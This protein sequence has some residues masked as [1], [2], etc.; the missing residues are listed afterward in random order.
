MPPEQTEHFLTAIRRLTGSASNSDIPRIGL[1]VS[2]GPDSLALLLLAHTALPGKFATATV[3]HGLRPGAADEAAY[4]GQLCEER[5]IPHRILKPAHAITGNI[6]SE[7]RKARYGLLAGWAE[8]EGC[9]WIATA[10]HADDQLET[11]LMRLARGS[12][13]D[14]LSGIRAVNGQI[15]RPLLDTSKADLVEICTQAGVTAIDDPSNLDDDFDRVRMRKW[16]AASDSPLDTKS[17][18]KSAGHLGQASEALSWMTAKLSAE[19]I[20]RQGDEV[21]LDSAG[22]P[23]EL[24]RRLLHIA[25]CE[26]DASYAPRGPAVE[27]LLDSLTG[28]DTSTIGNILCRGGAQWHF[29]AAPPRQ[30]R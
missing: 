11:L 8:E 9:C 26:I 1:A 21:L 14:G 4:V 15:I 19:R 17:A 20:S 12:G 18:A 24:Q 10:H 22:L 2:G 28:G 29:S 13:V 16:L 27:R 25:L 7:A 23:R 3:D 5:G 6:Q 30:P